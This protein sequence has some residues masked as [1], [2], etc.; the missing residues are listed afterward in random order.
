MRSI[1]V[2]AFAEQI[3]TFNYGFDNSL[4]SPT[5]TELMK[6]ANE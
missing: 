5:L 2:G 6:D 1:S 4:P 3:R